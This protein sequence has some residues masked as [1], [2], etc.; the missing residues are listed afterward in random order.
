MMP[1]EGR[2]ISQFISRC[3]VCDV[4]ANAVAFHSQTTDIPNCPQGW[5]GLWIGYSFVMVTDV[6]LLFFFLSVFD[7]SL[8]FSAYQMSDTDK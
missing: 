2:E 7:F 8:S 5:T 3:A 1:V 6:L 4:T